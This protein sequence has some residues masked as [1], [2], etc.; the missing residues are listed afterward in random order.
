MEHFTL[1][2]ELLYIL[3]KDGAP[4]LSSRVWIDPTDSQERTED[5][6]AQTLV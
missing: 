3:L 2:Y 1:R 4:N 6:E 5:L